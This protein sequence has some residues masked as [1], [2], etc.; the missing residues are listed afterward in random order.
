[1]EVGNFV[2]RGKFMRRKK[3]GEYIRKQRK[4][5]HMSLQ[6]LSS[7]SNASITHIS[8]LER[9]LDSI[10]VDLDLLANI[11]YSLHLSL[12][13]I[14]LVAGYIERDDGREEIFEEVDRF[15]KQ[16]KVRETYGIKMELLDRYQKQEVC[17]QIVNTLDEISFKYR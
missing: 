8:R 14:L 2:T 1:M 7:M 10:Y 17:Q 12:E 4:I 5:R 6:Q 11:A 15:L 3:L 13:E 16:P 9:G